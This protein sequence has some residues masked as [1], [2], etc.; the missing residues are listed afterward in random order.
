[1]NTFTDYALLTLGIIA[2]L[3]VLVGLVAGALASRGVETS[4]Q[5]SLAEDEPDQLDRV[6]E[7]DLGD[8]R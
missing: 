2:L 5:R 3:F 6:Q 1:M 7:R 4:L 8:H